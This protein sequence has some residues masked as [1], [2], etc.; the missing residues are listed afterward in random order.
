ML[1]DGGELGGDEEVVAATPVVATVIVTSGELQ[2][3]S[4]RR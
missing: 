3:S 4:E 1:D 2:E